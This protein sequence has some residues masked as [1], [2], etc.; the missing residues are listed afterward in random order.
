M[1][2]ESG[3]FTNRKERKG[4]EKDRLSFLFAVVDRLGGICIE[5]WGRLIDFKLCEH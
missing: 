3:D 1:C 5:Y 2:Y 4:A